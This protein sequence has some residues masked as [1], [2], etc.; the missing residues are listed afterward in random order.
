M[1]DGRRTFL[2]RAAGGVAALA[3]LL[4]PGRVL[5]WG[6]RRA[7]CQPYPVCE[8]P[9]VIAPPPR[10]TDERAPVTILFPDET[11]VHGT[12]GLFAWGINDRS[13]NPASIT[14][15]CGSGTVTNVPA[16][17]PNTWAF[18]I[19]G[20]TAGSSVTLKVYYMDTSVIPPAKTLGDSF[21]FTPH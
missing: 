14:A 20:L 10:R 12:G 3:G 13:V 8:G 1:H 11:T 17:T 7:V 16:P 5:A 9:L 4:V 21:T 19:T 18:N 6:R 15:T 2:R